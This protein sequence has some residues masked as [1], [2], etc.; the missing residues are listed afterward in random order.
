MLKI[1]Q[2]SI[3]II[4][5]CIKSFINIISGYKYINCRIVGIR[6]VDINTG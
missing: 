1:I 6:Y 3:W 2:T 5:V 4:M